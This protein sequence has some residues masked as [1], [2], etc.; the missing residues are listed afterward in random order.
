LLQTICDISPWLKVRGFS[1][2]R[3][4]GSCFNG[5][6]PTSFRPNGSYTPS[7]GSDR[8]PLGQNVTSGI[9]IAVVSHTA[10]W[11]YPFTSV[12]RKRIEDMLAG[13]TG[14]RR[15][16]EPIDLDQ[17]PSIP[18]GFIVQLADKLAPAHIADRFGQ[19]VVLDHI[20]DCQA[21]HADH[22][23][24]VDDACREFVLV[25]SPSIGDTSV[26]FSDY[27]TSFVAVLAALLFPGKP[28][29]CLRQLLFVTGCIA[30]IANLLT[31]RESHH[32]LDAKVKPNHLLHHGKGLD[33]FCY[34]DGDKIAVGAILGDRD[35]TGLAPFGQ[36]TMPDNL[37]RCIHLGKGEGL[38]IPCEGIGSVGSRLFIAF[39]LPRGIL[40]MAFKEVDKGTVQMPQGLLQGNGRSVTQPRVLL[41][42]RRQHGRQAVVGQALALLGIGRFAGRETP[43][44]DEAAASEG[45]SKDDVL[46]S[47]RI[48]SILVGSLCLFAHGLLALSLFL[49][50]LSNGSQNLAIERAIM[51]FG[52]RSYLLQQ[53]SREPNG[54]RLYLISHVAILTLNWLHIKRIAPHP[55]PQIRNAASIP[56]AEAQGFTRRVDNLGQKSLA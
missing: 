11:A 30:G 29:L 56:S 47:G 33:L 15:G 23:V 44:V 3:R 8:E 1:S 46:L 50:V 18:L 24:L 53:E 34:Q 32:R 52:D 10:G 37:Q 16:I 5:S 49:D 51:L 19:R 31:C 12:Q 20:L 17:G 38:F 43:V 6:R 45:L 21:L 2:S 35:R 22:L 4:R 25:V 13:T 7:T 27:E 28:S 39:R 9:G 14:L 55:K 26:D 36:R 41:F 40:G 54:Q 48:E 42:E